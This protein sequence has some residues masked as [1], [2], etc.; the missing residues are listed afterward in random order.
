MASPTRWTWVWVNSRSWWWTGRPGVLQ[1]MG[2]QRVGHDWATE[3]NWTE[4]HSIFSYLCIEAYSYY[5]MLY[6]T[7]LEKTASSKNTQASSPPVGIP[8]SPVVSEAADNFGVVLTDS[9]RHS[10]GKEKILHL[11]F[12]LFPNVT[13]LF[14]V[15]RGWS[16]RGGVGQDIY[17]SNY[18]LPY[19]SFRF[20]FNHFKMSWIWNL[21]YPVPWLIFK[22]INSDF[23][24]YDTKFLELTKR[25]FLSPVW[26]GN[27]IYI[28]TLNIWLVFF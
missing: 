20:Y 16:G 22:V 21:E 26:H 5:I 11:L 17:Y 10:G 28:G 14:Q 1:F 2:S 4:F 3:L 19:S 7:F 15:I 18:I 25:I 13:D 12:C 8:K 23:K 27:Q 6:F 9:S 24:C